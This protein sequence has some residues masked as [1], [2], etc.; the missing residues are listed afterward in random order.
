MPCQG[1]VETCAVSVHSECVAEGTLPPTTRRNVGAHACLSSWWPAGWPTCPATTRPGC[2]AGAPLLS[3]TPGA[4]DTG[5]GPAARRSSRTLAHL[6]PS[7]IH[8][9][10]L[11]A[12]TRSCWFHSRHDATSLPDLAWPLR[13]ILTLKLWASSTSV[14]ASGNPAAI[15]SLSARRATCRLGTSSRFGTRSTPLDRLLV[16]PPEM[17]NPDVAKPRSADVFLAAGGIT[18]PR[19]VGAPHAH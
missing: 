9:A 11:G 7:S 2:D 12:S 15:P 3:L 10:R 18:A 5:T 19:R 16:S 14:S 17:T 8:V 4:H 1:V 6:A 13:L